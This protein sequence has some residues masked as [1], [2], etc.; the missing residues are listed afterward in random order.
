V[1]G[2]EVLSTRAYF[3]NIDVWPPAPRVIRP[4]LWLQNFEPSEKPYAIALLDAFILFN[5]QMTEQLFRSA[6]RGVGAMLIDPSIDYSES[7]RRWLEFLGEVVLTHPTGETPNPS[8]SG[9][10]YARRMRKAFGL[11]QSQIMSPDR[12]IEAAKESRR[13]VL[14]VD[15]FAGSGNQFIETWQRPYA[16]PGGHSLSFSDVFDSDIERNAFY[17]PSLCTQLARER[18]YE[19]APAVRISAAHL[20]PY[21]AS[22]VDVNSAYIPVDLRNEMANVVAEASSRARIP[23]RDAFGFANL[24]LGVAFEDSVPDASLPIFWKETDAWQPL[25]ARR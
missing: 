23:P 16:Q 22:L 4:Q 8:D 2:A 15:D 7:R 21:T 9:F 12:A 10:S 24:G 3:S 14:F 17:A 19:D 11:H 25:I 13:P 20:I 18:I 5:E 1:N 6:V